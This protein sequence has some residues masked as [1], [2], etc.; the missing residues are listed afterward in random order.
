MTDELSKQKYIETLEDFFSHPGWKIFSE[1][2]GTAV[3]AAQSEIMQGVPQDAYMMKLGRVNA[4]KHIIAFPV[5]LKHMRKDLDEDK[6]SIDD[7]P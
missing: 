1:E 7:L 4:F 3:E 6:S 2:L 5:L